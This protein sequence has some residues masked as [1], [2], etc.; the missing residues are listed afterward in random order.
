MHTRFLAQGAV[1]LTDA[2][3]AGALNCTGAHFENAGGIALSAAR[4]HIGRDAVLGS[5]FRAAGTIDCTAAT[6]GGALETEGA[7]YEQ[8]ITEGA[9]IAQ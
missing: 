7:T 1:C 4:S 8:L 6:I 5:G 9:S 3:I 2:T